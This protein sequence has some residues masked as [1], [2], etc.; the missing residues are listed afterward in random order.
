MTTEREG[1]CLCGGVRYRVG[2]ALEMPSYCHCRMCQLSAGAPVM[3]WATVPERYLAWTRGQ[4][5]AYRSSATAERLFCPDCGTQLV[6]RPLDEEPVRVDINLVTLD[7]PSGVAPDDHIWTSSRLPWF[8]T[9]D[10]L[11]RHPRDREG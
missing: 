2:A 5:R 3:V 6:F 4:P 10:V 9:A 11:P 1:G 7:D 8:D